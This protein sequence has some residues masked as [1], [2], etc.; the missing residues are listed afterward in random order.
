MFS[1]VLVAPLLTSKAY[2]KVYHNV[3]SSI[4]MK[5]GVPPVNLRLLI[6]WYPMR[7]YVWLRPMCDVLYVCVCVCLFLSLFLVTSHFSCIVVTVLAADKFWRIKIR[8]KM[9]TN[10][11][12]RPPQ[13]SPLSVFFVG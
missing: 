12:D 7:Q 8:I 6:T 9:L 1:I 13:T 4:L 11:S 3:L 10:N 5:K 2:D